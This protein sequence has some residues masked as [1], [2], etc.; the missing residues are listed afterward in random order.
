MIEYNA[1]LLG[2]FHEIVE[3]MEWAAV[4]DHVSLE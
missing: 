3:C 2:W 1:D 4:V